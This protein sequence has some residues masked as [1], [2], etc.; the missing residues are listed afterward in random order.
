[1]AIQFPLG[2]PAVACVVIGSRTAD[3]M[4]ANAEYFQVAIPSQLWAEL[5]AEGLIAEDVPTP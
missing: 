2:H 1:V 4:R 3:Q 5:R